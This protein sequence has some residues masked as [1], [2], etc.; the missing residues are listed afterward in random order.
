MC[1]LMDFACSREPQ[2][3]NEERLN[4]EQIPV[5]YQRIEKVRNNHTKILEW[6]KRSVGYRVPGIG[7]R[8]P[9]ES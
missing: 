1:Y 7:T 3:E 8:L 4:A 6:D 2:S 9:G 5:F